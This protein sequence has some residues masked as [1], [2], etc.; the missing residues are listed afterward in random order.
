MTR[1]YKRIQNFRNVSWKSLK[2]LGNSLL[3]Q[4]KNTYKGLFAYT[5]KWAIQ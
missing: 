3:A 2:I 5:I 1:K 4:N